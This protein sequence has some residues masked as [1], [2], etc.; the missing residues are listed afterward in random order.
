MASALPHSAWCFSVSNR[1]RPATHK[2]GGRVPIP[3]RASP[4]PRRAKRKNCPFPAG[5]GFPSPVSRFTFRAA[6]PSSWA[7][8]QARTRGDAPVATR[9]NALQSKAPNDDQRPCAQG[10]R[11]RRRPRWEAGPGRRRRGRA[12]RARASCGGAGGREGWGEGARGPPPRTHRQAGAQHDHVVLLIHGGGGRAPKP[13]KGE[14]AGTRGARGYSTTLK[15][16]GE[17]SDRSRGPTKT[18][19]Q[20]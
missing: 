1:E 17:R 15:R 8:P 4:P 13:R 16:Q 2:G 7:L 12:G 14:S 3:N 5:P 9:P 10:Q 19:S 11:A 20:G 6:S 18:G